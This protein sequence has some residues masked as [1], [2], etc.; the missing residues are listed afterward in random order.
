MAAFAARYARAFADVIFDSKNG[1]PHL[2]VGDAQHQLSDFTAA[3]QESADL[4]EVFLD[5][6]FAVEQKVAILDKINARLGMAQPVRNFIAVLIQHG[7]MGA[8]GEIVA[9]LKREL[10]RRLGIS[11]VE[12]T[13]ARKLNES[14]RQELESQIAGLAGTRI[15]AAFREDGSLLGGVVV[16]IG[17][18]VYDGSIRGRLERLRAE[19]A[20]D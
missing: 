16:R 19:L 5:P 14:E 20:A 15:Q 9:E 12:V 8:Y 4:R 2:N 13:S 6:T 10:N 7:R 17:S 1:E 3:W 18:T 11:E